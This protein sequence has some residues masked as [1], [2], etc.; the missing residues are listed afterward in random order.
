MR[1]NLMAVAA[2]AA[3]AGAAEAWGN[4]MPVPRKG[5]NRDYKPPRRKAAPPTA[6][7]KEIAEW[8]KAVEAKKLEK[9]RRKG[10]VS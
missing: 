5:G 7:D 8:N 4:A 3:I 2:L 6:K 10:R 1:N 9:M